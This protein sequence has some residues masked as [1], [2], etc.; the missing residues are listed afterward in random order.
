MHKNK[1]RSPIQVG[2]LPETRK[3]ANKSP[4]FN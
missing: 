2:S 4:G 3:K 1:H